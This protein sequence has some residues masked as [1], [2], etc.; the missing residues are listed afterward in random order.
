[1]VHSLD[2]AEADPLVDAVS[3]LAT[4]AAILILG[5][6]SIAAAGFVLASLVPSRQAASAVG[7]GI[8]F[9]VQGPAP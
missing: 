4:A 8:L 3:G 9:H 5:T 2:R 6:A 1:M 7:L